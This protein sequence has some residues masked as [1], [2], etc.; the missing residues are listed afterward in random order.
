MQN[1]DVFGRLKW[2]WPEW[3]GLSDNGI[4]VNN[5]L[6]FLVCIILL[7]QNITKSRKTDASD[8]I[9]SAKITQFWTK[10][11]WCKMFSN[12]ARDNPYIFYPL[13]FKQINKVERQMLVCIILLKQ[14]I[15]KSRKTDVSDSEIKLLAI[16]FGKNH[17][18]LNK[19]IV[20]QNFCKTARGKPYMFYLI[21]FKRI[22]KVERQMS[23][24][25]I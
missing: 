20:L 17:A 22:N 5:C 15:T 4:F 3:S 6:H 23:Q 16:Y 1:T 13:W 14:N 7:K 19:E 9:I 24:M 2:S 12:T 8:L 11:F 21:W 25:Q 18:V 10:Q